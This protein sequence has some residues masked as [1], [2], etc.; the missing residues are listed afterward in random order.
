[1]LTWGRSR[2]EQGSLRRQ[3]PPGRF[4]WSSQP[5]RHH[6]PGSLSAW[7]GGDKLPCSRPYRKKKAVVVDS[8]ASLRAAHA[9][10]HALSV[11]TCSRQPPFHL[12]HPQQ[13]Q[14]A[15]LV[16]GAKHGCF[17]LFPPDHLMVGR[18]GGSPPPLIRHLWRVLGQVPD[19]NRGSMHVV[20]RCVCS[21]A[22][23]L[24]IFDR[25][26]TSQHTDFV[27]TS[28]RRSWGPAGMPAEP[29]LGTYT[30]TRSIS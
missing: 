9:S 18:R 23:I 26:L 1:M 8:G 15:N 25:R 28:T 24:R 17:L 30:G 7:E 19:Q 12:P 21:F 6:R 27:R 11:P 16:P 2:S 3:Q 20:I 10:A 5:R 13:G 14:R 4:S 22:T 29:L